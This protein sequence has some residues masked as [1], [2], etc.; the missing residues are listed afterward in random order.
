M[1]NK[2]S[3]KRLDEVQKHLAS[4]LRVASANLGSD[5]S[6][7]EAKGHIRSAM[8]SIEKATKK[9]APR[10]ATPQSEWNKTVAGVANQ[11]VGREAGQA[12]MKNL[13]A[14]IKEREDYL[15]GLKKKPEVE[16]NTDI[17]FTNF[18]VLNG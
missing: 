13:D 7:I 16:P 14:L 9:Q 6:V 2:Q 5:K 8:Q 11:P 10:S 4:A 12:I 1:H 15:T 18:D 3:M 17:D